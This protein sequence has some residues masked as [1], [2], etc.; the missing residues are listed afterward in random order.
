M[1]DDQDGAGIEL[2]IL[3]TGACTLKKR[4]FSLV[5]TASFFEWIL[6]LLSKTIINYSVARGVRV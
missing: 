5:W 4:D 3:D 1:A 2:D 6:S